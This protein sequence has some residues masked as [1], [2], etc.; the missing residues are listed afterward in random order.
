MTVE[1]PG[2][3]PGL[4]EQLK[5]Q[6]STIEDV[7]YPLFGDEI[8]LGPGEYPIPP[9]KLVKVAALG[10]TPNAPARVRLDVSCDAFF[11]VSAKAT[12][13]AAEQS[14]GDERRRGQNPKSCLPD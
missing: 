11:E 10:T 8:S 12:D 6:G 2:A 3:I 1:N 7:T 4:I 13:D 14:C 5:A 9:L